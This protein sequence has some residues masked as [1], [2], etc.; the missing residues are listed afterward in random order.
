MVIVAIPSLGNGGLN[1]GMSPRF[2]RCGSFTFVELGNNEIKSVK[3]VPNNAANAMGGAGIQ[4]AEVIGNN[5][6][7][8]VIAGFLGPNAANALNSLNLK[9]YHV[10]NANITIQEAIN[11]YIQG[12]LKEL[13]SSNVGSHHG[14]GG[15]MGAG[16][17][18]GGGGG[19]GRG[20]GGGSGRGRQL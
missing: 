13:N 17:G 15:G 16:R 20:M 9:I 2:G 7:N 19:M 5:N 10:P 12:N 8:I 6:A 3:T 11:L 14:M 18:M 4:A 1:D